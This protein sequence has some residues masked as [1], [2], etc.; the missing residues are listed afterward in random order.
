VDSAEYIEGGLEVQWMIIGQW[1]RCRKSDG[2]WLDGAGI[3]FARLGP[4]AP[5][6]GCV[7]QRPGLGR[8]RWTERGVTPRQIGG[9][10]SGTLTPSTPNAADPMTAPSAA[11]SNMRGRTTGNSRPALQRNGQAMSSVFR[12]LYLL[13]L[14]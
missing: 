5:C 13:G 7:V 3:A 14:T 11:E 4:L 1:I 8:Y 2:G 6:I 10:A 9:M 12:P